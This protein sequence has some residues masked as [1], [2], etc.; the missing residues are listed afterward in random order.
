MVKLS[1]TSIDIAFKQLV[2]EDEIFS[3]KHA[4]VT[5]L[6]IYWSYSLQGLRTGKKITC[7]D[8]HEYCHTIGWKIQ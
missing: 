3:L 5:F 8:G 1:Y 4:L 6:Y 7:R 2:G